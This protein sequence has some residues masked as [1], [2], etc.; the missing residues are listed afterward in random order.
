MTLTCGFVCA[1][2]SPFADCDGNPAN[3]CETNLDT[4]PNNCGFCGAVCP[5]GS[6]STASCAAGVCRFFCNNGF[7]NCDGNLETG[8]EVNPQTDDANCGFCGRACASNEVCS[9]GACIVP[10]VGGF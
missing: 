7:L 8:C 2:F 5:A 9:N 1:P 6:N 4:D 10:R 3:G